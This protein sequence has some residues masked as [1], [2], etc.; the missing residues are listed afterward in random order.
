MAFTT[1][2]DEEEKELLRLSRFYW[3]EPKRCEKA[4]AYLAGCVMLGSALEAFLML[5]V[6][7]FGGEAERTG[8]IP[9]RKGKPKPLLEWKLQ[10]CS[11]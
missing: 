6:N 4:K 9:M 3:Q 7:M 10:S 1:L 11:E 8:K 5:M 2:D